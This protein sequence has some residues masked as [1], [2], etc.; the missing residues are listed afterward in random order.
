MWFRTSL[1]ISKIKLKNFLLFAHLPPMYSL[2]WLKITYTQSNI[3]A[4]NTK[5]IVAHVI[6][7]RGFENI[8]A[9]AHVVYSARY[10]NLSAAPEWLVWRR[11][12]QTFTS[13]R[14]ADATPHGGLN[15]VQHALRAA[16]FE[17]RAITQIY[18][19]F[20]QALV[21]KERIIIHRWYGSN[22]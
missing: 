12:A 6:S 21:P 11:I 9:R 17:T 4:G 10:W 1:E 3:A 5:S 15:P 2:I 19:T 22:S 7:G 8:H 13:A 20:C 16:A 14:S 18:A